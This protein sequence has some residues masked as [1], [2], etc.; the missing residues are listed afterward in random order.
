MHIHIY[1]YAY[2][3]VH[4]YKYIYV[5]IYASQTLAQRRLIAGPPQFHSPVR[6]YI[7][8]LQQGMSTTCA[9][10]RIIHPLQPHTAT[11]S[12]AQF[13]TSVPKHTN[14]NMHQ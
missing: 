11:H 9:T 13:H 4:R 6:I 8:H 2:M 7:K 1:L 3:H 10:T 5:Y 14:N 12:L